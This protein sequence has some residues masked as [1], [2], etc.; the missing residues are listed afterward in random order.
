V[1]ADTGTT[2]GF[3]TL[4]IRTI[5]PSGA[6]LSVTGAN[7]NVAT[8][9]LANE[10]CVS[11]TLETTSTGGTVA[12]GE[13]TASLTYVS[14]TTGSSCKSYTDFSA[15]STSATPFGKLV[16]FSTTPTPGALIDA[17]IDWGT[18]AYCRPDGAVSG[19][20]TCPTT[21]VDFQDGTGEHPQVFC[22]AAAPPATPPWCTTGK[23][24][25]YETV[26]GVLSTR[27]LEDWS[28]FGDPK[29]VTR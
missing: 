12:G 11:D 20:P 22:D 5:S 2:T 25:Q 24:F 26:N 4:E 29:F 17:H 21:Y 23:R 1:T 10:L 13:V 28:G 9:T 14:N 15:S 18:F 27:I 3:D 19:V 6:S 8:F 16:N 7:G